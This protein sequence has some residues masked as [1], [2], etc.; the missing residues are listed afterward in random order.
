LQQ[1]GICSWPTDGDLFII[2]SYIAQSS[3]RN[4]PLTQGET[5]AIDDRTDERD[6][7]EKY[8]TNTL[9]LYR[10]LKNSLGRID[11]DNESNKQKSTKCH[12]NNTHTPRWP[13]GTRSNMFDGWLNIIFRSYIKPMAKVKLCIWPGHGKWIAIGG[14]EMRRNGRNGWNDI[15]NGWLQFSNNLLWGHTWP[16]KSIQL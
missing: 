15:L 16:A 10:E 8:L 4:A 1:S 6:W 3:L 5:K 7:A 12:L 13:R 9:Y 11:I 14:Q 2:C